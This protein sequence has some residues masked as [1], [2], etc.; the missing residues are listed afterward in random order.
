[1]LFFKIIGFVF[2]YIAIGAVVVSLANALTEC[3][4]SEEDIIGVVIWP[5]ALIIVVAVGGVKLITFFSRKMY[6][7]WEAVLPK[8]EE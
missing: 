7:F 6:D 3:T 2:S 8:D 4:P 1:M 5:L